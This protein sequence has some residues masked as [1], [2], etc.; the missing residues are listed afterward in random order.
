M[1]PRQLSVAVVGAAHPNK[2]GGNRRTEIAFCD[3]GESVELRPEPRNAYDEHAIAV[4]SA[5]RFQIGY[6]ASHRAV[7]LS[8][9]LRAGHGLTAIFQEVATWGAVIRVGV[10]CHPVL[11]APGEEPNITPA[12]TAAGPPEFWPDEIPP[13]D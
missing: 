11:P 7:F 8:R 10:D 3:P 1:P 12:D 4:F 5:R 13:D 6:V 9:L 2:D